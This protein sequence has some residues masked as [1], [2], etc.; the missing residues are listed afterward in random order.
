MNALQ[1]VVAAVLSAVVAGGC[2]GAVPSGIESAKPAASLASREP[3]PGTSSP[4]P[5]PTRC[6]TTIHGPLPISWQDVLPAAIPTS[7]RWVLEPETPAVGYPYTLI[8]V[9]NGS[10]VGGF[11]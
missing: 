4:E 3:A 1:G 5:D 2:T 6:D 7:S 8:V 10:P 9:D 11:T